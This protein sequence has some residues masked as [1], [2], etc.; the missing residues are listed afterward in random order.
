MDTPQRFRKR[1]RTGVAKGHGKSFGKSSIQASDSYTR[2]RVA[3][4]G[5]SC[6]SDFIVTTESR[7]IFNERNK[8]IRNEIINTTEI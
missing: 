8:V 1:L 4:V 3:L 6:K 7:H 2:S 5:M